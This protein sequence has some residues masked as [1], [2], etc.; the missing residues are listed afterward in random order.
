[1]WGCRTWNAARSSSRLATVLPKTWVRPCRNI[2]V[3]K[4][5]FTVRA[6]PQSAS[7]VVEL[8]NTVLCAH[9]LLERTSVTVKKTNPRTV[10]ATLRR[11]TARPTDPS[12]KPLPYTCPLGH[13][14]QRPRHHCLID[15]HRVRPSS[16]RHEQRALPPQNTP[17]RSPQELNSVPRG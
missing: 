2:V 17:D 4:P 7:A 16:A 5:N 12:R 6:C 3:S 8:Y 10:C 11:S 13:L 9:S 1:M 14:E 15:E